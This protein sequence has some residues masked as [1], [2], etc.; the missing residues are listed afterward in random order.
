MKPNELLDAIG[1]VDDAYIENA[2]SKPKTDKKIWITAASVAACL[3]I[4]AVGVFGLSSIKKLTK[5]GLDKNFTDP[6]TTDTS[7]QAT[8]ESTNIVLVPPTVSESTTE[9]NTTVNNTSNENTTEPPTAIDPPCIWY[10]TR[11]RNNNKTIMSQ[12][13][14]RIWPW[15]CQEMPEQFPSLEYNGRGYVIRSRDMQLSKDKVGKKLGSATMWGYDIYE[16]KKHTTTCEIYE[17]KGVDSSRFIA[18]KYQGYEGYYVF[19]IRDYYDP[20]ATLGDLITSLN[21]TETVPLTKIYHNSKFYSLT[22]TDSE[23]L[24]SMLL[25]HTDAETLE[26]EPLPS[27]KEVLAFVIVSEELGVDNLSWSLYNDG[28]LRTNIESYGYRY[29]IGEDAVEEIVQYA[30]KHKTSEIADNTQ[31]LI[32]NVTEIGEDYIKVNDAIMMK[33]PDDGI[34]FTVMANNM[35]IKRYI[36]SG[37]LKK[38][39]L[40]RITHTGILAGNHT[41]VD[42]AINLEEVVITENDLSILF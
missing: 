30:L 11:K 5:I 9:K 6:T 38:G 21:L 16:D 19:N 13:S 41:I 8:N 20:P 32:G 22:E 15:N 10:D 34:E 25:K 36:I 33:N 40:V 3:C 42:T 28:Y 29:Y 1:K 27:G 23:V 18:V 26:T 37:F 12:A 24:W 4:A 35:N 39:Q 2:R 7:A 14:A 17:I 31:Y